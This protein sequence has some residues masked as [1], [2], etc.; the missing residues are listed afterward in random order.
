MPHIT[1]QPTRVPARLQRQP[2]QQHPH[3]VLNMSDL[4]KAELR[5]ELEKLGEHPPTSW[6]K[7]QLKHRLEELTGQD[8]S[9]STKSRTKK[10]SEMSVWV[11]ELNKNKAR[12]EM[13][14]M[15]KIMMLS[16]PDG[17]DPV[18]FGKYGPQTYAETTRIDPSY[19]RCVVHT[20]K[21]NAA[22]AD[23]RLIRFGHW[24]NDQDQ[25]EMVPA[26]NPVTTKYPLQEPKTVTMTTTT[27]TST[28]SSSGYQQ[29][30]NLLVETVAAL[31][32]EV[33][34]L[35]SE[36]ARKTSIKDD[37]KPSTPRATPTKLT[38]STTTP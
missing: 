1:P 20:A 18:S 12:I 33:A 16:E 3:L 5:Q 9:V 29:Q 7:I 8:M 25:R 28:A 32:N 23:P 13:E 36:K 27:T 37:E 10:V 21:T 30:M 2:L 26:E 6:T 4:K 24:L 11:K 19:C 38:P 22:D 14:A 15:K 34:A 31:R 35:K 17:S